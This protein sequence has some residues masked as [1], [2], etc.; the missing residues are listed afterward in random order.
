MH[1]LVVLKNSGISDCSQDF[2]PHFYKR[3]VDD[4]FVTFNS[5]EKLKRFVEYMKKNIRMSN[6]LS[7]MS[8]TFFFS[9][10]DVKI[11]CE[12]N[13]LTTSV[14][15]KPTFSGVFTNFNSFITKVYRFGLVYTWLQRCFNIA[16]SYQKF[17]R[18]I[19]ALKQ[20]FK[21]NE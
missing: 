9:F 4:I 17:H 8:T 3:Y 2:Y 18:E 11:C 1:F 7:N 10:L 13:K 12:N 15:R 19:D 14:H 6:L 20:M 21:L 16:S 5:H